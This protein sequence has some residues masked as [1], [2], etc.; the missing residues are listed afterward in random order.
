MEKGR[1]CL[2]P[3]G[4]IFKNIGHDKPDEVQYNSQDL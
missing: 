3:K 2:Y 1:I 4:V